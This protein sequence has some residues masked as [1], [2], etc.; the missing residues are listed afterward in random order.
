MLA[1][2][3]H[4]SAVIATLYALFF[5]LVARS[6]SSPAPSPTMPPD[7]IAIP[8]PAGAEKLCAM[9]ALRQWHVTLDGD[10]LTVTKESWRSRDSLPF[11]IALKPDEMSDIGD[12]G[13]RHVLRVSDGW[14]V[15]FDDGEWDG[16]LWWFDNDG[17]TARKLEGSSKA[18]W[19]SAMKNAQP[20]SRPAYLRAGNVHAIVQT[21]S[22]VLAFTGVAHITIDEGSVFRLDRDSHGAW[23]AIR[24]SDLD[25]APEAVSVVS[26]TDILVATNGSLWQ[27]NDSGHAQKLHALDTRGFY[28]S[29]LTAH[30]TGTMFLA[31]RQYIVRLTQTGSSYAEQWFAPADCPTFVGGE[32]DSCKCVGANGSPSYVEHRLSHSNGATSI[33]RGPDGSMWFLETNADRIGKISPAGKI[34]EVDVDQ[35]GDSGLAAGQD[36]AAWFGSGPASI[37]R[38]SPGGG[39][40]EYKVPIFSGSPLLES[41]HASPDGGIWFVDLDTTKIVH[42]GADGIFHPFQVPTK[43]FVQ[44]QITVDKAGNVWFTGMNDDTIS[45]MTPSGDITQYRTP[46]ADSGPIEPTTGPDGSVWFYEDK[47]DQLGRIVPTDHTIREIP[48]SGRRSAPSTDSEEVMVSAGPRGLAVAGDGSVWFTDPDGDRIGH[49]AGTGKVAYFNLRHRSLPMSLAVD[50]DGGAW[51][52]EENPARIGRVSQAGVL[53]EYALPPF[54]ITEY[55]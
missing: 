24:V 17:K 16:S 48:L 13:D 25:G 14:L 47:A 36:G 34:T 3:L 33:T 41:I 29:S 22:G 26:P 4:T 54:T 1:R 40:T 42:L 21:S 11:A 12:R 55:E 46:T 43:D 35:V 20:G 19:Q 38:L 50:G 5:A 30:D 27:V 2:L 32:G 31:M 8:A 37:A 7:W 9:D 15:G 39:T 53:S 45:F 18:D 52:T 49:F 10:A 6:V 28:A 44:I 51:F 23:N